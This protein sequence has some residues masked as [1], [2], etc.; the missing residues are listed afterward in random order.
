VPTGTTSFADTGLAGGSAHAD[1]VAALDGAGNASAQSSSAAGT[2]ELPVRQTS[3]DHDP[4]IVL[5]LPRVV[6]GSSTLYG[7][8]AQ[9][10]RA[11]THDRA[12]AD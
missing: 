8:L 3:T 10:W 4:L 2:T 12:Q 6:S 9:Q 11:R 1:T 5:W 7:G